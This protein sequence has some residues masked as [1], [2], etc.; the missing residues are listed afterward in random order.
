MYKLLVPSRC[1]NGRRTVKKFSFHICFECG[2]P[3]TVGSPNPTS[4]LAGDGRRCRRRH[5]RRRRREEELEAAQMF[6]PIPG[7]FFYDVF[8]QFFSSGSMYV[9][10]CLIFFQC[11]WWKVAF[12]RWN[13]CFV[14]VK[15]EF[16]GFFVGLDC[17]LHFFGLLIYELWLKTVNF[18]VFL[19]LDCWLH[20][21]C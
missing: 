13:S 7:F 6:V 9:M 12:L 2:K 10:P 5:R 14:I 19:G 18:W 3:D 8:L 15:G 20:F 17:W 21:F 16:L 4:S 11:I 1:T